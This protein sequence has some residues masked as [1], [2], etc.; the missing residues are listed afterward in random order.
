M[1]SLRANPGAFLLLLSP[2]SNIVKLKS[3]LIRIRIRIIR[4][5]ELEGIYKD[6]QLQQPDHFGANEKLEHIIKGIIQTPLEH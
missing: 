5:V 1:F 6:H 3:E 2:T 4:I